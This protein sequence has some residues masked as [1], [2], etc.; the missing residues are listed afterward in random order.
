MKNYP[1][2]SEVNS[3][4]CNDGEYLLS[5]VLSQI[6]EK[7][8]LYKMKSQKKTNLANRL[9]LENVCG[10]VMLQPGFKSIYI[11]PCCPCLCL[12]TEDLWLTYICKQNICCVF[13]VGGFA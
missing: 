7:A 6:H 11:T 4:L 8:M 1:S 9:R 12:T 2:V 3:S 5:V 10:G 13:G